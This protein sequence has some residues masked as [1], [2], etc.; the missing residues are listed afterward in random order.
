MNLDGD[1]GSDNDEAIQHD[2][3]EEENGARGIAWDEMC[4]IYDGKDMNL[5]GDDGGNNNQAIHLIR[6]YGRG[7]E[8]TSARCNHERINNTK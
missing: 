4:K 6:P 1:G 2:K 3:G 5:E 8:E 7:E